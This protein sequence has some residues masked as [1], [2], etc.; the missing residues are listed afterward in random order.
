M[1]LS[2]YTQEEERAALDDRFDR[3]IGSGNGNRCMVRT[4]INGKVITT[5]FDKQSGGW[6]TIRRYC[7]QLPQVKN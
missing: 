3:V 7:K 2:D 1:C 5:I 4:R 6:K